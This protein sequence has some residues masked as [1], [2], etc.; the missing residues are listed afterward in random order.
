MMKALPSRK[1]RERLTARSTDTIMAI[2]RPRKR[3]APM[4]Y[5][6][7]R[8]REGAVVMRTL[9]VKASVWQ[10]PWD[11]NARRARALSADLM[12]APPQTKRD[13]DSRA[14]LMVK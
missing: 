9:R 13:D 7:Y 2:G 11:R 1:E 14:D 8:A 6:L 12:R 3:G 10:H 4:G 5:R